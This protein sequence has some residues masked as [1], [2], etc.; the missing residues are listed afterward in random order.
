M[1]IIEIILSS[2]LTFVGGTSIV[3]FLTIRELKNKQKAEVK[4]LEVKNMGSN[5]RVLFD[6]IDFLTKTIEG[7]ELR[8]DKVEKIA[9]FNADCKNRV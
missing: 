1:T 6:R 7:L 3:Q 5:D 4:E 8:L 2:V 9:C